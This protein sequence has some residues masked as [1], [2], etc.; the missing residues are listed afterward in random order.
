MPTLQ[1]LMA[2]FSASLVLAISPGPDNIFVLTQSALY[3]RL[4]GLLVTA[5][6]CTGLLVHTAIVA[7]GVAA[8]ISASPFL[9]A[10]LKTVG[11]LYLLYLAWLHFKAQPVDFTLQQ[12]GLTPT[13]LYRRG[14][15]MNVSNPK[16]SVFFLAFLPQFTNPEAGPIVLQMIVLGGLFI[17]ATIVIFGSIALSAGTIGSRLKKSPK[18]QQIMLRTTGIILTGLALALLFTQQ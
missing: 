5:G 2:F 15:I 10:F 18:I 8:L 13:Q 11:A 9:F 7:L 6:L 14:I 1:S 16:V 4:A 3:G 12:K 17:V